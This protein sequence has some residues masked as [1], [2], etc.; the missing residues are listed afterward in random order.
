MD[1]VDLDIDD[2]DR[3][4]YILC[5]KNVLLYEKGTQQLVSSEITT[6]ALKHLIALPP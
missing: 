6:K 5:N 4:R 1:D 2:I 3:Y